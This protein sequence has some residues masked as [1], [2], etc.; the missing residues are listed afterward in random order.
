MILIN[1]FLLLIS[2]SILSSIELRDS[3]ADFCSV[4]VDQLVIP[5]H[6]PLKTVS[7]GSA[8]VD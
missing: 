5:G 1:V 6:S 3:R 7:L 2:F 4:E 8:Q